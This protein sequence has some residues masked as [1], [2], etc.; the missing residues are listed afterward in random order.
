MNV[1]V[2]RQHFDAGNKDVSKCSKVLWFM[3][4]RESKDGAYS[5]YAQAAF[6]SAKKAAPS[7]LPYLIWFGAATPMTAWFELNGG[8]VIFHELSFYS[9]L[10]EAKQGVLSGK[11]LQFDIPHIVLS[12]KVPMDADPEY[13]LYT[14]ADV[15]FYRDFTSCTLSKPAILALGAETV[16]STKSNSGAIYL[17][18]SGFAEQRDTLVAFAIEK[19]FGNLGGSVA[20]PLNDQRILL[21]DQISQLPDIFNWKGY[22]GGDEPDITIFPF[23]GPKPKL[24]V[25]GNQSEGGGLDCFLAHR[26]AFEVKCSHINPEYRA[27]FRLSVDGGKYY[28]VLQDFHKYLLEARS[29]WSGVT[30]ID[31]ITAC[32]ILRNDD[33]C[34]SIYGGEGPGG[35][36]GRGEHA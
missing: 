6:L 1:P 9:Q 30:E 23:H 35:G 21:Q 15:L 34:L 3:A 17:N 20:A 27:V 31:M 32:H 29:S 28:K 10:L 11:F 7:L 24:T 26:G 18:V 8:N 14:D 13:V 33:L 5:E 12:M 16:L 4:L 2:G 36:E 19:G 25:L 22:W